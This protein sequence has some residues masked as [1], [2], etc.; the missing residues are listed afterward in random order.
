MFLVDLKTDSNSP[1]G[2]HNRNIWQKCDAG[3]TGNSC[4]PTITT[5]G[6]NSYLWHIKQVK[7]A[8]NPLRNCYYDRHMRLRD[9]VPR[10]QQ[11]IR[12]LVV[13]DQVS[14]WPVN[15][16]EE[17]LWPVEASIKSF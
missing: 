3:R 14:T 15:K 7:D 6:A 9:I 12:Y 16:V 10:T 2:Q 8:A 17:R 1:I 11:L 5:A 13:L 4:N